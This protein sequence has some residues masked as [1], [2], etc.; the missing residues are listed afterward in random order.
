MRLLR[1]INELTAAEKAIRDKYKG[2]NVKDI[3]IED[4]WMSMSKGNLKLA[5]HVKIFD[6]PAVQSCPNAKDCAKQCYARKAEKI[7]P[8]VLPARMRNFRL[9]KEAPEVLKN[10]I[11]KELKPGD[12]VRL[13]SSGDMYSQSYVDMWTEIAKARPNTIFYTYTKTEGMFDFSRLKALPNFNIVSSLV[14]GKINFGPEEEIKIT[15][16]ETGFPICPCKKGNKVVC[17]LDCV[18]CQSEPNVLFIKH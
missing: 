7:Y 17:G 8:G 16:K 12:V 1:L 10:Q 15:A 18:L 9:A 14:N 2:V 6:L 13:H 3:P 4:V 5:K 11:L